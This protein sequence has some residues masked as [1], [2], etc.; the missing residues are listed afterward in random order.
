MR[1]ERPTTVRWP[2]DFVQL[3][4]AALLTLALV[5]AGAHFF[6]L[7]NKLNFSPEDYMKVQATYRGWALFGVVIIAAIASTALHTYLVRRNHSA[8]VW[9]IVAIFGLIAAQVVF[10]SLV[11][12]VNALT[13]NWTQFPRDF[14]DA[15]RQWEYAHAVG[16]IFNFVALIAMIRSIQASRPY[17][18]AGVID[19]ITNNIKARMARAQTD[20]PV[21]NLAA[22]DAE[23]SAR[24]L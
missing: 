16:S 11:Q 3:L 5:P 23:R 24:N 17:V 15:R 4:S 22:L 7:P 13:D 14:E 20:S 8:Y 9:S 10:W 6:E 18:S 12:P 19:A 21:K 1:Y 2:L